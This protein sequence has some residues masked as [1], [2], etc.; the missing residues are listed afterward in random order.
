MINIFLFFLG[1]FIF[2]T[3]SVIV[4]NIFKIYDKNITLIF[5]FDILEKFYYNKD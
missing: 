5:K 4:N 2:G 3:T 1:A